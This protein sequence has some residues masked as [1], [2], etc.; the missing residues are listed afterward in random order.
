MD[1]EYRHLAGN[2][3]DKKSTAE[4]MK[5]TAIVLYEFV[6]ITDDSSLKPATLSENEVSISFTN[7]GPGAEDSGGTCNVGS[8]EIQINAKKVATAVESGQKHAGA[9]AA[10]NIA[11]HEIGERLTRVA[12]KEK[13]TKFSAWKGIKKWDARVGLSL[14]TSVKGG[15]TITDADIRTKLLPWG[16]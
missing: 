11:L 2:C 1:H 6:D 16:F 13:A 4:E 10:A 7:P 8:G 14:R 3:G 5:R 9:Y 12:N 15:G